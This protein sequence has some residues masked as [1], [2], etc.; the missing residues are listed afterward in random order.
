M[1]SA[2]Q[3]SAFTVSAP[4]LVRN[5]HA[6]PTVFTYGKNAEDFVEWA[7]AGDQMG[8]DIQPVPAHL[9]NLVQFRRSLTRGIFQVV[10]DQDVML[11]TESLHRSEWENRQER[12]HNA[13][14]EAMDEVQDNDLLMLACIAPARKGSAQQCQAPV[15]VRSKE[16][17]DAPP[18][19]GEH[20]HMSTQFA[21][22]Y[23]GRMN[24]NEPEK[25][26]RK[27]TLAARTRQAAKDK[28]EDA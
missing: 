18:L 11:E 5:M 19:C 27:V 28:G 22:E 23:T 12:Q 4:I 2:L 10:E 13:A 17:D 15:T 25:A 24:G 3:P 6:G 9:L 7:G 20:R 8:N 21:L 26:W 16:R 14:M 1:T